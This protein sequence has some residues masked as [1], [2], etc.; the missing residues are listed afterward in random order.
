MKLIH[1]GQFKACTLYKKMYNFTFYPPICCFDQ[2]NG[3]I[4]RRSLQR[5]TIVILLTLFFQHF[6]FFCFSY[7]ILSFLEAGKTSHWF[8]HQSSSA[9]IR[10]SPFLLST[11]CSRFCKHVVT[12]PILPNFPNRAR[13]VSKQNGRE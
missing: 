5:E 8:F 10:I 6:F 12:F 3:Y 13:R 9:I 4:L 7:N 11:Y 2:Q 1:E